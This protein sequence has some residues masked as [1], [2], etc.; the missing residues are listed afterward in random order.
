MLAS[1]LYGCASPSE[2]RKGE[3]FLNLNS[4]KSAKSVAICVSDKWENLG[5]FNTTIPVT[6]R[7][8]SNGFTVSVF[9]AT[10]SQTNFLLDITETTGGSNSLYFKGINALGDSF[11]DAVRGCQ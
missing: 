3:P 5:I 4:P 10:T 11:D 1:F 9:N 8:T 2:M 7:L 6:M